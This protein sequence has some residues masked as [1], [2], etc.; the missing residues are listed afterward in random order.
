LTSLDLNFFFATLFSPCPLPNFFPHDFNF[1]FELHFFPHPHPISFFSLL[2]LFSPTPPPTPP[3]SPFDL[4]T[5]ILKLKVKSSPFT[6]SLINLKCDILI[7]TLHPPTPPP[8]P[9]SI[10][11]PTCPSTSYLPT[12]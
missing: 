4:F 12:F 1:F 2:K 7:F 9:S 3:L 8:P 6:Y 11:L 5:Y 10:Y